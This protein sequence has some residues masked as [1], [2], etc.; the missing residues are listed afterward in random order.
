MNRL[1]GQRVRLHVNLQNGTIAVS[2]KTASGWRVAGYTCGATLSNATARRTGDGAKVWATRIGKGR[3]AV[4]AWIEGTLTALD[5]THPRWW[6]DGRPQSI[7]YNPH[8]CRDFTRR[9]GSILP[10]GTRFGTF[11]AIAGQC[12]YATNIR[13]Q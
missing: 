3:R 6:T 12:G 1:I 13:E 2:E 4:V 5:V 8:R 9:D 7:H 11:T 10:T